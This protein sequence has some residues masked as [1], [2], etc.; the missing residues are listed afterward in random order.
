M[1][2]DPLDALRD[3]DERVAPAPGFAHAL[4]QRLAGL[5]DLPTT[6]GETMT[7]S[8][9]AIAQRHLR[10]Y[11]TLVGAD[12]AIAFYAEAFGAVV[13]GDGVFRDAD[14]RIGHAELDIDGAGFYLADAYPE[15]GNIAPDPAAGHSVALHL[16]VADTD[17][18]VARAVAAGATIVRPPEDQ[19]YGARSA[20]LLDPFG[21]RWSIMGPLGTPMSDD[22]VRRSMAEQGVE[23][24][25]IDLGE[26]APR[27]SKDA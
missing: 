14:G 23:Y 9:T 7:E 3:A 5:L 20:T 18:T 10:P 26:R 13:V 19:A 2:A 8:S 16:E 6:T 27:P 22:E 17:A 25:V 4:R 12:A 11:L 21:H 1:P 15:Y 24:E